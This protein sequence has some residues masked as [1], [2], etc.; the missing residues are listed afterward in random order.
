MTPSL[1]TQYTTKVIP[2]LKAEFGY[3]N[4]MQVPK[5]SKVTLNIGYGRQHKDKAF[6][7]NIEKTLTVISGQ[8][9][10]HNKSKKSISNFK[11]REGLPIGIS[12]TLR[13]ARMYDFL[14]KLIH[15]TLPRVRDFRGIGPKSFDAQGNYSF[16]FKESI[17]FPEVVVESIDKIHGLQVVITTT[18]RDKKEGRALLAGL[19]FPFKDK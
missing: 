11:I 17:A 7:E 8:K 13:G 4:V 1:L 3:K 19:G 10:V 5:V 15:I 9:P 6:I 2:A 12:V 16:G 18:A 14:Y